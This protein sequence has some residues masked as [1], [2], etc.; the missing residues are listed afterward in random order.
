MTVVMISILAFLLAN[1]ASVIQVDLLTSTA[2]P[3]ENVHVRLVILD[4]SATNVSVDYSK[5]KVDNAQVFSQVFVLLIL[6]YLH[7]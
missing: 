4:K 1:L 6:P 7:T 2:M 5:N 3:K